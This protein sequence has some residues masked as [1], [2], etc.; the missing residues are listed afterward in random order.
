MK[1]T[2]VSVLLTHGQVLSGAVKGEGRGGDHLAL[3]PAREAGEQR[4]LEQLGQLVEGH[5][6]LDRLAEVVGRLERLEVGVELG[7]L[8]GRDRGVGVGFTLGLGG[9]GGVTLGLG[10]LRR[11]RVLA[12]CLRPGA[13]RLGLGP[14]VS[15]RERGLGLRMELG[16]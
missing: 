2:G 14:G 11:R 3:V 12:L 6:P 5:R 7:V 9:A 10:V 13:G 15:G 4:V 1:N 16:D 8:R